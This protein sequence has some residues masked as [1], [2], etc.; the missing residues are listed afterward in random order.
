MLLLPLHTAMIFDPTDDQPPSEN[1]KAQSATSEE[2]AL[3]GS[4]R[5]SVCEQPVADIKLNQAL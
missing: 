2:K 5:A 1:T 4:S 3:P